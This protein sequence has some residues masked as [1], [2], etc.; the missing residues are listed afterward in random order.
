[1]AVESEKN[2]SIR[3]P[4][5]DGDESR[6]PKVKRHDIELPIAEVDI[7]LAEK[8]DSILR[9]GELR[10][11]RFFTN[12]AKSSD[13]KATEQTIFAVAASE[14]TGKQLQRRNLSK[15][16]LEERLSGRYDTLAPELDKNRHKVKVVKVLSATE[17]MKL[18]E[19]EAKKQ[20]NRDLQMNSV[21]G[22]RSAILKGKGAFEFSSDGLIER[23][24]LE[25]DTGRKPQEGSKSLEV[26]RVDVH[27][28]VDIHD[29]DKSLDK[30]TTSSSKKS[31]RFSHFED[32]SDGVLFIGNRYDWLDGEDSDISE[33]GHTDDETDENS[34]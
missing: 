10:K 29:L 4:H 11:P 28:K 33:H 13:K 12:R 26:F 22:N 19:N 24:Q 14:T 7:K 9:L 18:A 27:D 16:E 8:L 21:S 15:K 6:F 20:L 31:V 2:D 32:H 25:E 1:M 34:D 17:S 30:P 3:R 23:T 5:E